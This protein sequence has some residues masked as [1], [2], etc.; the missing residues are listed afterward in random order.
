MNRP[1]IPEV[2][3][4]VRALYA[5]PG[6]SVGCC[7]HLILDEPNSRDGD[8]E[9]CIQYARERGHADCEALGRTLLL[10]SRT[11]RSKIERMPK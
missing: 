1:T 10:M 9:Y 11:Q 3:P 8:V 5:R 2:L 4:A 6:G 7:L